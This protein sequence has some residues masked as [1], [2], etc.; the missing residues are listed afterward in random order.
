MDFISIFTYL[1]TVFS[2][3]DGTYPYLPL[4]IFL[5]FLSPR[6]DN[7]AIR[8][9]FMILFYLNIKFQWQISTTMYDF[10]LFAFN[11][12]F[13]TIIKKIQSILTLKVACLNFLA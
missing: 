9:H 10:I 11:C 3:S 4:Y 13:Q 7:S 12:I 6:Y 5:F 2:R 8:F 1:K